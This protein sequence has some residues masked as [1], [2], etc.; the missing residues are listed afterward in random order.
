MHD[1]REYGALTP[2]KDD[3]SDVKRAARERGERWNNN[4]ERLREQ[5]TEHVVKGGERDRGG[6]K[7]RNRND[8]EGYSD[9]VGDDEHEGGVD[10]RIV[11]SVVMGVLCQLVWPFNFFLGWIFRRIFISFFSFFCPFFLFGELDTPR[12]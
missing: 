3:G 8:W 2:V 9:A 1:G 10:D 5:E 12:P 11:G 7:G 4:D 6:E